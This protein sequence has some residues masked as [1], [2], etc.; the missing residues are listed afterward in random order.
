MSPYEFAMKEFRE[1]AANKPA[2]A[3]KPVVIS[4]ARQYEAAKRELALR[5]RNY[6]RWVAAGRLTQVDADMEI[7]CMEAIVET[8]RQI[9]EPRLL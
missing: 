9:A 7:A 2:V 6:P 3:E 5:R 4:P 8:L 1:M